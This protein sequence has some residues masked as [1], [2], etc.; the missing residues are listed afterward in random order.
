MEI[1]IKE[2]LEGAASARGAA[3]IIDVFRAFSLEC[4]LYAQGAARIFAVGD[5]QTALAL[6]EKYPD[7][8]LAGEKNGVPLPGFDGNNSPAQFAGMDLSGRTILHTTSAGTRG[9]AAAIK[10]PGVTEVL[11]GSLVN[12]AAIAAYLGKQGGHPGA[13]AA[14]AHAL[15]G[16]PGPAAAPGREGLPAPI[17]PPA[18]ASGPA[19][20]SG[21]GRTVT[22]VAMGLRTTKSA[23]EDVLCARYIRSL[24]L[25]EPLSAAC[26]RQEIEKLKA[27]SGKRF[28]APENQAL[29]PE[30]DFY[31]C[32]RTDLFPFVL[33]AEK[34]AEENCY[35]MRK[36]LP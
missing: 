4:Y 20:P 2:L 3:V 19:A 32:T 18:N 30:A 14:A 9:I 22:L 24:L 5:P 17:S 35:R 31:M 13:A 29:M 36:I 33:R 21:D 10:A 1:R 12:A 6:K 26:M 28:F 25:G 27:T 23:E 16:V 15:A 34:T 11:A 7:A 8:L